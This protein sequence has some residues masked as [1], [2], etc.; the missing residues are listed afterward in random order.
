MS[1]DPWERVRVEDLA[2]GVVEETP[3][4]LEL[5]HANRPVVQVPSVCTEMPVMDVHGAAV[6]SL[7]GRPERVGRGNERDSSQK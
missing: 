1:D 5:I 7:D 4:Q 3:L 6:L 2:R